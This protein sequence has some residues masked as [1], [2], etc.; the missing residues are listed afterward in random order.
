MAKNP[1]MSIASRSSASRPARRPARAV[2]P[3]AAKRSGAGNDDDALEPLLAE[4]EL[5]GD[6]EDSI[7]L[8]E[9]PVAVEAE[10]DPGPSA[11]DASDLESLADLSGDESETAQARELFDTS[12]GSLF[13]D[14]GESD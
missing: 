14:D 10:P 13:D 12:G 1:P 7:P 11:P 4:P 2:A 3:G 9:A 6:P 5:D 8:A